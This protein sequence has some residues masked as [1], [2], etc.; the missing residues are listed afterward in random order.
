MRDTFIAMQV[1]AISFVDEGVQEVLD[2]FNALAGV[3]AICVSALSWSRG[4]AGRA[5]G[6]GFP[7]HGV[8]E[9]DV[10]QGGA[11]F[12]PDQRY[13]QATS[14]RRFTAPDRLYEGFDALGDVVGEARRRGMAVFPYYCET[15]HATPTSR[16]QPGFFRLLEVDSHK[17]IAPRPCLRNLAYRSWWFGV[18][19]NWLTEYD[20]DGLMWGIERQGP[21]S[22]LLEGDVATCFCR[23]CVAEATLRGIDAV[24]AAEGFNS[25]EGHL[26]S[27]RSGARPRDGHFITFHRILLAYPEILQWERMWVD[28]HKSLYREISGLVR[29]HGDRYQVGFGLWQM[30]DTFNPWLRAEYDPGEYSNYADWLKPVLYNAPAGARFTKYLEG[31]CETVLGDAT[32]SEWF[33][34]MLRVLGLEGFGL[35][36]LEANGFPARYVSD[37]TAR[38]VEATGGKIPVYPGLGVGVEEEAKAVAPADV[39]QMVEAAFEGGASGIIISRNYSEMQRRNLAAVGSA[40]KHLGLL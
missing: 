13:Y 7:D 24:R 11:F 17:R 30:I 26:Q 32:P 16:W 9:P 14:L 39:E 18:V 8:A 4:N 31:L 33:P 40:L 34:V 3:N 25:L 23:H 37:F 20:I 27:W 5:S 36:D 15:A 10:L 29:F 22:A 2:T 28:A 38:Y 1:G 35:E 19:E 12:K 21:L 6:G